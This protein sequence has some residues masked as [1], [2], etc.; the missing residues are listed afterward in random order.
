MIAVASIWIIVVAVEFFFRKNLLNVYISYEFVFCS[1]LIIASFF[2]VGIYFLTKGMIIH[3]KINE[4]KGRPPFCIN[5]GAPNQVEDYCSKC[6]AVTKVAITDDDA[7]ASLN[8]REK[9]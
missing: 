5:C 9:I 1:S 2:H 6:G 8:D 7:T 4:E 3:S